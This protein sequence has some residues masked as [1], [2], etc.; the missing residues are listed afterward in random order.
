MAPFLGTPA[1]RRHAGRSTAARVGSSSGLRC[2]HM[3]RTSRALNPHHTLHRLARAHGRSRA[4]AA[5][6]GRAA[7]AGRR[8]YQPWLGKGA[9]PRPSAPC[10]CDPRCLPS[11]TA[12]LGTGSHSIAM[13]AWRG[14]GAWPPQP[15]GTTSPGLFRRLQLGSNLSHNVDHRHGLPGHPRGAA[16]GKPARRRQGCRAAAVRCPAVW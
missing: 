9:A 12:V 8:T 4:C 14:A 11:Q 16:R 7:A 10:C 1:R 5:M 13:R 3:P 6:A 2:C 15:A